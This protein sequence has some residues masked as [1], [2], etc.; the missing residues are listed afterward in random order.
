M[1][2]KEHSRSVEQRVGEVED[3]PRGVRLVLERGQ[4]ETGVE[5]RDDERDQQPKEDRADGIAARVRL[6]SEGGRLERRS[7]LHGSSVAPAA[8]PGQ[9]AVRSTSGAAQERAVARPAS[10]AGQEGR[11][12]SEPRLLLRPGRQVVRVGVVPRWL[13]WLGGCGGW[14]GGWLMIPLG[15]NGVNWQ[16]QQVTSEIRRGASG[17]GR[18]A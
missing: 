11:L 7:G 15:V 13:W 8:V 18:A 17:P 10:G 2:T 16:K 4:G 9:A 12:R 1:P 6:L 3:V 5:Q 14:N